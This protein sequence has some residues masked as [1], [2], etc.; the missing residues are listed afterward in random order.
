MVF[1]KSKFH[2]ELLRT[3]LV[4]IVPVLLKGETFKSRKCIF[5]ERQNCPRMILYKYTFR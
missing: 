3:K 1:H 5:V 4:E 2:Q